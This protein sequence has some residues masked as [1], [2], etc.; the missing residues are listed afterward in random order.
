M[1]RQELEA[2]GE[3]A[4]KNLREKTLASGFPFMINT[5]LLPPDQC[6]LEYP[7]GLIIHV[8]LDSGNNDFKIIKELSPAESLTIMEKFKLDWLIE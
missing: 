6:Y 5:N 8:G 3:Q 2:A 7:D 4:L 1:T